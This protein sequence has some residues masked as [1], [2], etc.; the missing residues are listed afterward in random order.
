MKDGAPTSRPPTKVYFRHAPFPTI[1][2]FGAVP[3]IRIRGNLDRAADSW[4]QNA[5]RTYDVRGHGDLGMPKLAKGRISVSLVDL[6]T[7]KSALLTMD[8][9]NPQRPRPTNQRAVMAKE[10]SPGGGVEIASTR[11][12]R[13]AECKDAGRSCPASTAPAT[14]CHGSTSAGG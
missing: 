8:G 3:A 9:C 7:M 2:R 5:R 6:E 11:P 1:Q 14:G 4:C 10:S 13:G 12:L